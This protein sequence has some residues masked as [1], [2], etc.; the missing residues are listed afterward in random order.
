MQ[1]TRPNPLCSSLR[2]KR[3]AY[4]TVN[5]PFDWGETFILSELLVMS[6]LGVELVVIPRDAR[7]NIIH[8]KAKELLRNTITVPWFN[9]NVVKASLRFIFVRPRQFFRILLKVALHA[10]NTKIAIKNL[11]VLPKSLY[12]AD[13]LVKNGISHIHAHWATTPSTMALIISDITG[14]TW[15]F[16][17]HSLDILDNN[18]LRTKC[19]QASFVRVISKVKGEEVIDIVQSVHLDRKLKVIHM[20]VRLPTL[21][22]YEGA[23]DIFVFLCPAS[24]IPIKG[25]VFLFEACRI[26]LQR[27]LQFR[28]LL[29]GPGPLRDEMIALR[30]RLKLD[31][32]IDFLGLLPNELLINMYEERRVHAVVLPSIT[33]KNK[34]EGIPVALMEAMSYGLPVIATE[35]GGIPELLGD[36]AGLMVAEKDAEALARAMERLMADKS[37]CLSMGR[38][39]RRKIEKDFDIY[40]NAKEVLRLFEEYCV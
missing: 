2:M 17:A 34:Q 40:V 9:V 26:L 31:N 13:V 30:S 38:A 10:R 3:V 19:Q 28:C 22:N 23:T 4:I 20:G 21:R 11:I 8:A 7:K 16:T 15:S 35:T 14:I 1:E 5:T 18:I 33:V 6:E 25:H 27:G 36:G 39:G 37:L 29:A 32:F 12:L 24:L